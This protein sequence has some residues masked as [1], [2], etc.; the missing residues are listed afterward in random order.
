MPASYRPDH[1]DGYAVVGTGV[2]EGAA[3]KADPL[4]ESFP[5]QPLSIARVASQ[6]PYPLNH[7]PMT[8]KS[9]CWGGGGGRQGPCARPLFTKL[10]HREPWSHTGERGGRSRRDH[11]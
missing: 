8:L 11:K 10:L 1:T 7:H 9:I 5:N 3:I 2:G 4:F 6:A